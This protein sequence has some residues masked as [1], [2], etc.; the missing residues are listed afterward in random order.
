MFKLFNSMLERCVNRILAAN[1]MVLCLNRYP[2]HRQKFESPLNIYYHQECN[3]LRH[4]HLALA[5]VKIQ[6]FEGTSREK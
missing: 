4:M 1:S 6:V 2:L 3:E 5:E